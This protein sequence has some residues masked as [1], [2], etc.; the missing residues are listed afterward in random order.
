M[1]MF[2]L[3]LLFSLA[4]FAQQGSGS[5]SGGVAQGNFLSIPDHKTTSE[6]SW[7]VA[8]T[9]ADTNDCRSALTPCLTIQGALNKVPKL[10]QHSV[11]VNVADGG[12]SCFYV[13]GF[14]ADVGTQQS[15]GGLLIDGTLVTDTLTT[16][17]ATGTVLSAALNNSETFST[18]TTANSWTAD[19]LVGRRV[20]ITSGLGSGQVFPISNNDAGVLTIVGLWSTTP[21]ATSTYAI[22]KSGVTINTACALPAVPLAAATANSAAIQLTDNNIG[23]RT[24][25][26]GAV[27]VR[28]IDIS[29]S[30]GHGVNVGGDTTAY[31]FDT[32]KVTASAA[33]AHGWVTSTSTVGATGAGLVLINRSIFTGSATGK[34]ASVVGVAKAQISNSLA[35]G[36]NFGLATAIAAEGQLIISSSEAKNSSVAGFI[37]AGAI[38]NSIQNSR[39]AC[40]SAAAIAIGVGLGSTTHTLTSQYNTTSTLV[41]HT[42][43]DPSCGIGI[44]AQGPAFV[45]TSS[46]SGSLATNA[47]ML[48]WGAAALMQNGSFPTGG[49][50]DISLDNSNVTA[51]FGDLPVGQCLRSAGYNSSVCE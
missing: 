17:T 34:L 7:F 39:F 45:S 2:A 15:S 8:T 43:F 6:Q 5:D 19:D 51:A 27:V 25:G 38:G 26:G 1:R 44:L 48:N 31:G 50:A 13:S 20:Q 32:M 35:Y 41:N 42:Y 4:A 46:C 9:G 47:M 10:L 33:A 18:M 11:T 14:T 24:T 30:A 40:A 29:V 23:Y 36:S 37:S 3:S 49:V 21:N 22:V 12:Y 28:N 16:G